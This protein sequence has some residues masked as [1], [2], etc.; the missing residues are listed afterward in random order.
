VSTA[1]AAPSAAAALSFHVRPMERGDLPRVSALFAK[2]LPPTR[3]GLEAQSD[4]FAATL[5]DHPW[6]DPEIPSLVCES[7]DGALVG[8]LGCAVRRARLGGRPVRVAYTAHLI[9]DPDLPTGFPAG[10]LVRRFCG[11]PQDLSVTDTASSRARE[12]IEAAGGVCDDAASVSWFA[13]FRR[14]RAAVSLATGFE[15]AG[16]RIRPL[17]RLLGRV[18]VPTRAPR[19][20]PGIELDALTP[21]GAVAALP[22]LDRGWDLV[23]DY[24]E[25]YLAWLLAAIADEPG[26]VLARLVRRG[27]R[28]VGWFVVRLRRGELAR[29]LDVRAAP[30]ELGQVVDAM[31]EEVRARGALGLRGRLDPGLSAVLADHGCLYHLVHRVMTHTRRADVRAAL[32]ARGAALS[33]FFGEWW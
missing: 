8:F 1:A 2:G 33:P 11:G 14:L 29:V 19:A 26:E 3:D 16:P 22:L 31:F 13:P 27:P 17:A 25:G 30:R 9:A 28:T 20:I 32:D 4:W 7:A 10:L 15:G 18:P 23:P 6:A 5:L 24:D 21:A 12:L